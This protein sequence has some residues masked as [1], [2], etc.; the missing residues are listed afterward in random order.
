[1]APK[2]GITPQ[3]WEILRIVGGY[4]HA[5]V[6]LAAWRLD[7]FTALAR[8][9]RTAP[10]LATE[11]GVHENSLRDVLHAL[12]GLD[13]LTRD[14]EGRYHPSPA[15]EAYLSRSSHDNLGGFHDFLDDELYPAWDGLAESV[16][17]GRPAT[18]AARADD[19]Y[20]ELYQAPS[21][22]DAFLETMDFM[23][24]P[25]AEQLAAFDWSGH[26]T[27]AD[28]GG[29]RGNLAAILA[30]KHP[31]LEATVFD[32]PRL[33]PAFDKHIAELGLTDR[34]RFHAGDFFTDPLPAADALILGHVLHNWP[35]ERRRGL[36]AKAFDAVE[37][38]GALYVYDA[39]LDDDTPRL[40][41]A[42]VSLD[43]LVWS[44]G[45]AEYT[46]G[47]CAGWLAEAGFTSITR[48]PHGRSSSVV[49][50]RKPS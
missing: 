46:A 16:R 40:D 23:N 13:L 9:A 31:H 18:V 36:V 35:E 14:G 7:V 22:R 39:M 30:R 6:L 33:R 1:M 24:T 5:K 43:M 8:D 37:P 26:R 17:T 34:I 45:G 29:A 42:L 12:A 19:P 27:V 20:G 50:G 44:A 28:I 49:I 4:R 48:H 47:E 3:P 25:L 2:P 41:N 21:A 32:L 38:G 10:E 15:A 11:L